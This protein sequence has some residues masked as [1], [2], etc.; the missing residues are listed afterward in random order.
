MDLRGEVLHDCADEFGFVVGEVGAVAGSGW[1][2]EIFHR[3]CWNDG[4]TGLWSVVFQC[5]RGCSDSNISASDREVV[6]ATWPV[7]SLSHEEQD[8]RLH[9]TECERLYFGM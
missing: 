2:V 1:G 6:V 3:A 8:D 4:W 9:V 5:V 7:F